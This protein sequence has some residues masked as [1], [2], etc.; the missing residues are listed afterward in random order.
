MVDE[1]SQIV[2]E[3]RWRDDDGLET[4]L[5]EVV[6]DHLTVVTAEY[7]QRRVVHLILGS[8]CEREVKGQNKGE[9]D[10]SERVKRRLREKIKLFLKF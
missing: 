3:S 7:E 8:R 9:L 4:E 10:K 5:I 2:D 1:G 6:Q